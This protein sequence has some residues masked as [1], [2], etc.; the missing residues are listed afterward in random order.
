MTRYFEEHAD[1]LQRLR[2]CNN[3]K[4][5]S[6]I[7]SLDVHFGALSTATVPSDVLDS[8]SKSATMC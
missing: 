8:V 3:N 1:I 7:D 4:I 6:V 5:I 2:E